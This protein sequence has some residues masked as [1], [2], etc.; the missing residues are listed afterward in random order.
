M[1]GNLGGARDAS[2][3]SN[4]IVTRKRRFATRQHGTTSVALD[5]AVSS[6]LK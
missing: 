2:C 5:S 4:C 6:F 1:W 3:G